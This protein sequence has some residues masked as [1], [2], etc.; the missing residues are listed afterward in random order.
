VVSHLKR[1][2]EQTNGFIIREPYTYIRHI[3]ERR[4][5]DCMVVGFTTT[6]VSHLMSQSIAELFRNLKK[7]IPVC[8]QYDTT[9]A[10]LEL[11]LWLR[12]S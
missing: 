6:F 1:T 9:D 11:S 8:I 3:G 2:K 12:F 7:I 10:N 4:G 5:R